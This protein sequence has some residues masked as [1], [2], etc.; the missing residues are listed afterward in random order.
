MLITLIQGLPIGQYSC[1]MTQCGFHGDSAMETVHVYS[2]SCYLSLWRQLVLQLI[3]PYLFVHISGTEATV[4]QSFSKCQI[5]IH[6]WHM[7]L[8]LCL[9]TFPKLSFMSSGKAPAL[10]RPSNKSSSIVGT[11]GFLMR[12]VYKLTHRW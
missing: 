7:Y 10:V 4:R 12:N 9:N 2:H 5:I 8:E 11:P 1:H 3:L 6:S